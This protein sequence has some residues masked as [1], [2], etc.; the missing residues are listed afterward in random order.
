M[1][2]SQKMLEDLL[3]S[4]DGSGENVEHAHSSASVGVEKKSIRLAVAVQ[5]KKS[6]SD[7]ETSHS[8]HSRSVYVR[9]LKKRQHE[10]KLETD[11]QN[12]YDATS[13]YTG[14]IE[15]APDYLSLSLDGSSS[16]KTKQQ[17]FVAQPVP[18][19]QG[20]GDQ[21]SY[22]ELPTKIEHQ[23]PHPVAPMAPA[24]PNQAS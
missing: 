5:K 7:S 8:P 4:A 18:A 3:D 24:T 16:S 9:E 19:A 15:S 11:F 6:V 13:E 1:E 14:H 20:V 17:P 23:D 12:L 22:Q 10:A 21:S 2:A